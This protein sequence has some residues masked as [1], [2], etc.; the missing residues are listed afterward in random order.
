MLNVQARMIASYHKVEYILGKEKKTCVAHF[1]DKFAARTFF[2]HIKLQLKKGDCV[3][4]YEETA[5]VNTW[6]NL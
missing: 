4:L 5:L 3:N 6:E 1:D 2:E